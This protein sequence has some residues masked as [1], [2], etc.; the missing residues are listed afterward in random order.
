MI[1]PNA[2]DSP[3]DDTLL[4]RRRIPLY[5]PTPY[6]VDATDEDIGSDMPQREEREEEEEEEEWSR[7]SMHTLP[8]RQDTFPAPYP[9]SASPLPR[10]SSEEGLSW[11]SPTPPLA[12]GATLSALLHPVRHHSSGQVEDREWGSV[13]APQLQTPAWEYRRRARHVAGT[14]FDARHRRYKGMR[15]RTQSQEG[16]DAVDD[17]IEEEE[18]DAAEEEE[19]NEEEELF[20]LFPGRFRERRAAASLSPSH[21]TTAADG[22]SALAV[23]A[24]RGGGERKTTPPTPPPLRTTDV[25]SSGVPPHASSFRA[26]GGSKAMKKREEGRALPPPPSHDR[27]RGERP[28]PSHAMAP[29]GRE[30]SARRSPASKTRNA[31][32][33]RQP[34]HPIRD[35]GKER[36]EREQK[37]VERFV[38]KL[39]RRRSTRSSGY[40]S[41]RDDSRKSVGRGEKYAKEDRWNVS[42]RGRQPHHEEAEAREEE[43]EEVDDKEAVVFRW[44]KPERFGE[45]LLDPIDP[46]ATSSFP[47][48]FLSALLHSSLSKPPLSTAKMAAPLP[49]AAFRQGDDEEEED[50]GEE[51][52]GTHMRTVQQHGGWGMRKAGG[53]GEAIIDWPEVF[54]PESP[55]ATSRTAP[56]AARLRLLPPSQPHDAHGSG[57]QRKKEKKPPREAFPSKGQWGNAVLSPSDRVKGPS[58][59]FSAS[60]SP[61]NKAWAA[62]GGG[63]YPLQ[64]AWI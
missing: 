56:K 13:A 47:L 50:E 63:H 27:R 24:G 29:K 14:Y 7:S 62:T 9:S 38:E 4:I 55:S 25:A 61:A 59:K 1:E 46:K 26:G 33:P 20:C 22:A 2:E 57:G 51:R 60:S 10:R 52:G 34:L 21:P 58:S 49:P 18:N 64:E 40:R 42:E 32:L 6:L 11:S 45:K 30:G 48:S 19:D 39:L 35:A 36:V 31:P 44:V 43:E 41:S 12:L 28:P 8:P 23:P 37:E 5:I 53:S 3:T 15:K 17:G 16:E 54:L